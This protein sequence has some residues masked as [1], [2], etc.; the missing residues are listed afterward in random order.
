MK[1]QVNTSDVSLTAS[2]I[3]ELEVDGGETTGSGCS[4]RFGSVWLGEV[5]LS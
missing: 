1:N 5:R 2:G 4:Y 3:H